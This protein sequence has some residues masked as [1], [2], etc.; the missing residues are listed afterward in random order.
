MGL[1]L[2]KDSEAWQA[3]ADREALSIASAQVLEGEEQQKQLERRKNK[4]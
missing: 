1:Q 4:Q 3:V 2:D